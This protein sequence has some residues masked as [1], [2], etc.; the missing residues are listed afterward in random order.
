[1]AWMAQTN[2]SDAPLSLSGSRGGIAESF[3]SRDERLMLF[4]VPSL[5]VA[6]QAW[7]R[8]YRFT[9]SKQHKFQL[10]LSEL[11]WIS[12]LK[13]P[14]EAE[15]WRG[16]SRCSLSDLISVVNNRESHKRLIDSNTEDQTPPWSQRSLMP[17]ELFYDW[18][19]SQR[20]KQEVSSL[21]SLAAVDRS[22][23]R[24]Q[25]EIESQSREAI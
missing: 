15:E 21:S 18:Q 7:L 24:E 8:L 25:S 23:L 11:E 4:C 10:P 20:N 17:R 9:G 19:L 13:A 16:S 12:V 22:R 2:L 5:P 6:N 3:C 14:G 1:M